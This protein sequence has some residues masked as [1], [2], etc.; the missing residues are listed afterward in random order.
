MA[1]GDPRL[2]L[3]MRCDFDTLVMDEPEC[4]PQV[5]TSVV[6]SKR[7]PSPAPRF[8]SGSTTP[9]GRSP[10][11]SRADEV[12]A[13][14]AVVDGRQRRGQLRGGSGS[15]LCG[16]L[17]TLCFVFGFGEDAV[18]VQCRDCV[19]QLLDFDVTRTRMRMGERGD[20]SVKRTSGRNVGLGQHASAS[21]RSVPTLTGTQPHPDRPALNQRR[22]HD[23]T[24]AGP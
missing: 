18:A 21:A 6:I 3:A 19:E 13:V 4:G 11:R 1:V 17:T 22:T 2:Q 23:R 5:V 9:S 7:L 24:I 10:S 12:P 8:G 14:L 16:E 15:A 20:R